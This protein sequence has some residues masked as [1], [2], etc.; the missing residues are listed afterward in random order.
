MKIGSKIAGGLSAILNLARSAPEPEIPFHDFMQLL[1]SSPWCDDDMKPS[2]KYVVADNLPYDTITLAEAKS[3]LEQGINH[4]LRHEI[5]T[6][7]R[8]DPIVPRDT[9][10]TATAIANWVFQAAAIAAQIRAEQKPGNA[11]PFDFNGR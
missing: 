1:D 11:I 3:A 5:Q 4:I 8:T 10:M 2:F 9:K 6:G 7:K